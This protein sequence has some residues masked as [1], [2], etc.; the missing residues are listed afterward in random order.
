ME[1]TN[2]VVVTIGKVL[3]DRQFI[4][5]LMQDMNSY[6]REKI[7]NRIG[8]VIK[9]YIATR[10]LHIGYTYVEIE[11]KY[12]QI[13]D[14]A[15]EP[16]MQYYENAVTNGFFTHS[17]NG[18]KRDLIEDYGLN[19][20]NRMKQD[21]CNERI[22]QI[23]E[24]R[25][26]LEELEDILG[27]SKYINERHASSEVFITVPGDKTVNYACNYAPERL[28]LGPLKGF[29][30]E[31]MVVGE[32]KKTYM[33]RAI[34]KKIQQ[35][36]PDPESHEYLET[37]SLA[38]KV[39]EYFCSKLPAVAFLST[40]RIQ[41][42]PVSSIVFK[43]GKAR[44]LR[45]E[46]KHYIDRIKKPGRV[47]IIGEKGKK[48]RHN[49]IFRELLKPNII[50]YKLKGTGEAVEPI[51]ERVNIR[52][53]YGYGYDGEYVD[54][55]I[56]YKIRGTDK[57]VAKEDVEEVQD[58]YWIND[59]AGEKLFLK[60]S[61]LKDIHCD[62]RLMEMFSNATALVDSLGNLVTLAEYM[63]DESIAGIID[64]FDEFEMKQIFAKSKGRKIGDLVEYTTCMYVGEASREQLDSIERSECSKQ[65]L[66]ELDEKYQTTNQRRVSG[67]I[68]DLEFV[69]CEILE[70][71]GYTQN[72]I[73]SQYTLKDAFAGLED[74]GMM[75]EFLKQ[76]E[77][78][79]NDPLQYS[80]DLHG[81]SHT[82]RVNFLAM[83]IMN[84][85]NIVGRDRK[86]ILE[87][88]KN[89]DIGRKND[90]EDS[91]HGEDSISKID[92]NE[93][94][95]SEFNEEEQNLIK[96]VIAQHSKSWKENKQAI[97]E[98][99]EE[100]RERYA[101]ILDIFKDA[102]KLDRV[103]LDPQGYGL[104]DGLDIKRLSLES[105]KR[106]EGL[107]YEAY[108]KLFAILTVQKQIQTI[109]EQAK[110]FLDRIIG[111][112]KNAGLGEIVQ[113]ASKMECQPNG[114][115]VPTGR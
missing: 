74:N 88:V 32:N 24:I 34:R 4:A 95:L 90:G 75:S 44:P 66:R 50:A 61:D 11:S 108:R 85:E 12:K 81:V 21:G 115:D 72:G 25:S 8:T 30:N 110:G 23:L 62:F 55:I 107:A 13:S 93:G 105:S 14:V 41:N 59:N 103:R 112:S 36:Y 46:I 40:Q 111:N 43:S 57:E 22:E 2:D 48:I 94:R 97:S 113:A 76:D 69:K 65:E 3:G 100:L 15:I 78:I 39:I 9:Y 67:Q 87:I 54:E 45:D 56:G 6:D 64:M 29:I 101:R 31:P 16:G 92:E 68:Q 49:D 77:I 1:K 47:S 63:P 10:D 71:Q 89:H 37:L 19:Y 51:I 106:L 58:G 86:I 79:L 53:K 84:M 80:S 18:Y 82:R 102:D 28:Y 35:I 52:E 98:L 70:G 91:K 38:E 109:K 83:A 27:R 20:L 5:F 73:Q 17:F 7:E 33:M 60:E 99:P 104:I 42:I 26:M 96:F 114:L